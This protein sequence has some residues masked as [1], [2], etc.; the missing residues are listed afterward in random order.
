MSMKKKLILFFCQCSFLM[1]LHAQYNETTIQS[2]PNRTE[3]NTINSVELIS[4]GINM[5]YDEA[6]N[7]YS[8]DTSKLYCKN[9]EYDM[10]EEKVISEYITENYPIKCLHIKTDSLNLLFVSEYD[11]HPSDGFNKRLLSLIILNKK[12]EFVKKLCLYRATEFEFDIACLLNLKNLRIFKYSYNYDLEVR[13]FQLLQIIDYEPYVLVKNK[14]D[15]NINSDDLNR[16]L[17][18]L[19]WVN[20]FYFE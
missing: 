1:Y 8:Y 15:K 20:G 7:F 11:C 6:L 16:A 12:F 5:T 9:Q 10:T 13:E 18:S 17:K 14:T 4:N 19:E 3:K 2:Y